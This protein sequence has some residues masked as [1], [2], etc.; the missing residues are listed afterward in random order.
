MGDH[1][2]EPQLRAFRLSG[3]Q[4]QDLDLGRVLYACSGRSD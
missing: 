1:L 2:V 4:V 3:R